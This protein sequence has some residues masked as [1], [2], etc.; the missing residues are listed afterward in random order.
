M[1]P[2]EKINQLEAQARLLNQA[3]VA[4]REELTEAKKAIEFWTQCTRE[5]RKNSG[6]LF[7][8]MCSGGK[9]VVGFKPE[10][11]VSTLEARI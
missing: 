10:K 11:V 8:V 1:K 3:N 7:D 2:K 6:Y 5:A 9:V 4:L